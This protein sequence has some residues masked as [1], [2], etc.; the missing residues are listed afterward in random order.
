[1][2][3][4]QY[5]EERQ[6][7]SLVLGGP[8][9]QLFRRAHLSDDH[10]NM[11]IR[12]IVF[13]VLIT[14]VP[15]L[16]LSAVD[17]SLFGPGRKAP[18]FD[19]VGFHLRF[20][21]VGPML[22]GSELL[23]HQRLR[24]L[25]AQFESRNLI[26]PAEVDRFAEIV[27]GAMRWRNSVVAE[28]LLLVAVYVV[29][30][31][32]TLHRYQM[33]GGGA[34]YAGA[35]GGGLSPA[36]YWLVFVSLP[37][38]QFLLLRW[39][40]RLAVWAGFLWRVSKLDL[41]LT[42]TH[43]DKSGG[44]GFLAGSLIA[45]MPLAAAHGALF[46][47]MIADRILFTGAKLPQFQLDIIGGAAFLLVVFAG[48][49]LVFMPR[50][51]HVKRAGMLEFG[52]LAQTYVRDFRGKWLRGE[53]PDNEPLLGTGDIQSLADLGNSFSVAQEMRITPIRLRAAV[54][55]VAAFL[56]P[57]V[58]LALTMMPAEKLIQRLLDLIV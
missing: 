24:P 2:S 42:A 9:Y 16:A 18:F 52:G 49:L 21:V 1:V 7:F 28:A 41:D 35:D 54:N 43:P 44:L 22:I 23:V 53:P 6:D 27:A 15:L 31:L 33:L 34:W 4:L 51:A 5:F 30:G 14:W 17:G 56:A 26:K 58:P 8:L 13:A 48:P 40:Y 36:G 32:F 39:Y 29:G 55:F 47:G 57:I 19:D 46:A 10:L 45:F 11:V 12:R 25:V 37:L 50:L 38:L 20:L 3:A